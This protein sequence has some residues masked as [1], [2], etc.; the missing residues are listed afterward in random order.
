MDTSTRSCWGGSW[1]PY[2][3]RRIKTKVNCI[4]ILYIKLYGSNNSNLCHCLV[5]AWYNNCCIVVCRR[6]MSHCNFQCLG[7]YCLILV[8]KA[9]QI[10]RIRHPQLF[11]PN[12]QSQRAP[13]SCPAHCNHLAEQPCSL[14]D[15]QSGNNK[16]NLKW[17]LIHY[18][19]SSS[20]TSRLFPPF[21]LCLQK[22]FSKY[23]LP[24]SEDW[25]HPV[26]NISLR[27]YVLRELL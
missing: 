6:V 23:V 12:E 1:I 5:T 17:W 21:P 27:I 24:L 9:E 2:P 26:P 15:R 14:S 18:K 3:K 8:T 4:C 7:W 25:V 13:W 20:M 10:L 16:N 19:L 22:H 11:M